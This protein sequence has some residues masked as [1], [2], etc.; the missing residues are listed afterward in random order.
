MTRR[1]LIPDLEKDRKEEHQ[2]GIRSTTTIIPQKSVQDI[3][4]G[5]E[6]VKS[7]PFDDM[8][9]YLKKSIVKLLQTIKIQK[10]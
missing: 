3:R 2:P 9:V 5:N 6:E 4:I 1:L 8:I 10:K 7:S